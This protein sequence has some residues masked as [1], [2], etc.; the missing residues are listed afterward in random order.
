MIPNIFYKR[1]VKYIA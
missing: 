1:A